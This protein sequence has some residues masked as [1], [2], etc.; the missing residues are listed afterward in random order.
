MR[1]GAS[2]EKIEE[3]AANSDKARI[4]LNTKATKLLTDKDGSV[5]G[6]EAV[7]NDGKTIQEHVSFII[8]TNGD[9]CTGDGLKMTTAVGGECADLEWVQV[10]DGTHD[11]A[12]QA[13]P[14]RKKLAAKPRRWD[15]TLHPR[16]S[17]GRFI[18]R[19]RDFEKLD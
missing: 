5:C 19:V 9:H 17:R 16:D 14:S 13:S 12:Q 18:R 6:V 4:M 7:T 10:R 8:A 3:I 1:G 11:G 2:M 15:P